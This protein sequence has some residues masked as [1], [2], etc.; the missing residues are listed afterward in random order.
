IVTRNRSNIIGKAIDSVLKQTIKPKEFI[1]IDNDSK[2][3]T[4]EILL[5]Y[6]KKY[7]FFKIYQ[8]KVDPGVC[9]EINLGV[10]MVDSPVILIMDDD[11]IL[12]E[13]IW[14]EIAIKNLRES[15]GLVWGNPSGIL[16]L[17]DYGEFFL[18]CAFVIRKEVFQEVGM[19]DE[20]FFLYEND[21][22]LT[23]RIN[24]LGYRVLSLKKLNVIHPYGPRSPRYYQ[25]ALP[26]RL[27]IYWKYYPFWISIIMTLLH[28]FQEL[29]KMK[30][31]RL[32]KFLLKGIKRF[33]SNLYWISLSYQDRMGLK[34]FIRST[35]QLRFP[36]FGY[37][38]VKFLYRLK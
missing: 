6:K 14:M 31:F 17:A 28:T 23:V 4:V 32:L 38:L 35:Y 9:K 8:M 15:I 30:N 16:N 2:D 10:K 34:E 20:K 1:I 24:R 29:R 12:I 22:D 3:E 26:N 37:K 18:G 7:S 33:F 27:L 11:A 13:K 25:F 5:K 19:Y 21:T 36:I